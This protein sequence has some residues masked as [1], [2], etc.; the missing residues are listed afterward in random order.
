M[1]KPK[2]KSSY[3]DKTESFKDQLKGISNKKEHPEAEDDKDSAN[4]LAETLKTTALYVASAIGG[5]AAG[6]VFGKY[7]AIAAVPVIGYGVHTQ[8]MLLTSAG[9]G[10]LM[11]KTSSESAKEAEQQKGYLSLAAAGKRVEDFFGDFSGKL[12]LS[13]GP[14]KKEADKAAQSQV[15]TAALPS[16]Q[17]AEIPS[18]TKE[19]IL[20][21]PI[22]AP[23]TVV[24]P[25]YSSSAPQTVVPPQNSIPYPYVNGTNAVSGLKDMTKLDFY[26]ISSLNF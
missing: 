8:N 1:T 12:T 5:G 4:P 15:P 14:A 23:Q 11:A 22:A 17:A 20:R 7:S 13:S 26:D 9:I 21:E 2:K 3:K 24:Q 25:A 18:G 6:A 19:E 10:M 16:P